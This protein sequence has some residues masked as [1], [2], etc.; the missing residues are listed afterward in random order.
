MTLKFTSDKRYGTACFHRFLAS[1]GR[2]GY[3]LTSH[4]GL[5]QLSIVDL[6][7]GARALTWQYNLNF[8]Y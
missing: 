8:N 5:Y 6:L 7:L 1:I 4:I 2:G 3:F